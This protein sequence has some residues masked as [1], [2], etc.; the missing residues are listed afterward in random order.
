[1]KTTMIGRPS[2][3]WKIDAFSGRAIAV[4]PQ[5]CFCNCTRYS[6][7]SATDRSFGL[8]LA[9]DAS[10]VDND[11]AVGDLVDMGEVVLDVDAGAARMS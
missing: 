4:S 7:R 6:V 3:R 1:M 10:A 11:H 9:H 2:T 5:V 8:N